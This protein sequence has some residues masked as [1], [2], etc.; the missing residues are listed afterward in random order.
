LHYHSRQDNS[1]PALAKRPLPR[2]GTGRHIEPGNNSVEAFILAAGR[3]E[4]LRPLTDTIPKPLLEI[5]GKT[6]IENHI[7]RLRDA[8]FDSIVINLSWLGEQIRERVGEGRRFGVRIRY[9]EEPPGA[10][11][12]AGGIVHALPLLREAR[13]LL[14][15]GDIFTDFNYADLEPAPDMDATL[16]LVDNPAHHPNGDFCLRDGRVQLRDNGDAVLTYAGIGWYRRETFENLVPGRR[17]LRPVL[18]QLIA[19]DRVCG[20]RYAGLWLDVGTRERLVQ[21][22]ILATEH[23]HPPQK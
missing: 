2:V 18:E 1:E 7:E 8:G 23:E 13:F 10:L 14:V 16:V 21:A 11:E 12:T 6:L 15:S 22:D 19:E 4:R 20:F 3:G 5:G 17:P 9:S